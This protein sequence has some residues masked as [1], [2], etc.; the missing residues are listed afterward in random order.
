[1]L[2]PNVVS[3]VHTVESEEDFREQLKNAGNKLVVVDFYATWCGPCKHIAPYLDTFSVRYESQIIVLKVDVD[4]LQELAMFE[5]GVSSMPTFIFFKN[6]EIVERYS[7]DNA[8]KLL[9]AI[10]KFSE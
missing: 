10:E 5:Y 6:G 3:K 4:A 9:N 7:D 2:D 1:M 8:R